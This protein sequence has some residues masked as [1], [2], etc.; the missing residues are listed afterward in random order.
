MVTIITGLPLD[1]LASQALCRAGYG[2]ML[3]KR[4]RSTPQTRQLSFSSTT[5]SP[6]L[7]GLTHNLSQAS[8]ICPLIPQAALQAA[9][10]GT[11]VDIRMFW[12]STSNGRRLAEAEPQAL[13]R[14]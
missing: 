12:T 13:Q 5:P 11:S 14:G 2:L 8:S 9:A 1:S 4:Y 6:A 3:G 7:S 10:Q